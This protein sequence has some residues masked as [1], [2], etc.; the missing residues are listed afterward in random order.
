[1]RPTSIALEANRRQ[2]RAEGIDAVSTQ[3]QLDALVAPS[4][5]PAW[6]TDYI[7]GDHYTGGNSTPAAV[8]GYPSI[9]VPAGYVSRSPR[10]NGPASEWQSSEPHG[11]MRT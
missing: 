3:Y 5:G 2:T 10:G 6:L 1:M 4:G 8:A 9:T 11:A 7:N